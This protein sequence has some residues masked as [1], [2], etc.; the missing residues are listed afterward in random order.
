MVR[1]WLLHRLDFTPCLSTQEKGQIMNNLEKQ[2]LRSGLVAFLFALLTLP[3]IAQRGSDPSI[4]NE[5]M[6]RFARQDRLNPPAMGAV[7]LTGSSSIARWNDQAAKALAPLTVIPR[8][9]GGSVMNDVLH[10]LDTVAL[11]YKPRAIL[12]YEGDNDISSGH[13]INFIL[14]N[15]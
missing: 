8:G 5:S 1:N 6:E 10:H 12:I 2:F 15:K 3:A 11:Q 13:R 4:W 7:L 9:F 14:K